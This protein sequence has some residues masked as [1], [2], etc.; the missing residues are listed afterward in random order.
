LYA[1]F[2]CTHHYPSATVRLCESSGRLGGRI[3]TVRKDSFQFEGGAGRIGPPYAQPILWKLLKY[4]KLE[5]DV[6]PIAPVGDVREI[7]HAVQLPDGPERTAQQ[8]RF[9]YDAEFELLD[10]TV[11]GEYIER[12]FYGPFF[13]LRGGLDRITTELVKT[14]ER[15]PNVHIHLRTPVRRVTPTHV[16]AWSYDKLFVCVDDLSSIAFE[17]SIPPELAFSQAVELMRVY[18]RVDGADIGGKR[19]GPG[20][21]RMWLPIDPSS[22]LVQIYTDSHWARKWKEYV[23]DP[24][25]VQ[26]IVRTFLNESNAS[27]RLV[28]VEFWKRGVHVWT[29]PVSSVSQT[30]GGRVWFGGEIA[31]VQG[32]GWMEGALDSVRVYFD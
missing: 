21:V 25:L 20:P 18:V 31:S 30:P 17:V 14:L 29:R 5:Q 7:S 2:L 1:A 8:I 12:H 32:F 11:A 19:T 6:Y 16:D 4:L 28:D 26:D 3:F 22:G 9:G 13:G 10:R 15:N 27:V 23:K 24:V